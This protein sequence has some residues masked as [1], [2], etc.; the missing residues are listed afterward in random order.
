MVD[1]VIDGKLRFLYSPE[2]SHDVTFKVPSCVLAFAQTEM[3]RLFMNGID[4]DYKTNILR[5]VNHVLE[6]GYPTLV[7]RA[8]EKVIGKTRA[9]KVMRVLKAI[10]ERMTR[11]FLAGM[12]DYES[13][14]HSSP[15][16][17]IVEYLPKEELAALAESLVNLTSLKRHVTRGAETVGGPIDVAVISRGDGFIWI[18]RKH[19]FNKELNPY[20]LATYY[21]EGRDETNKSST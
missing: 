16:V 14:Q 19:Y 12:Q 5:F 21:N 13:K 7:G 10:G 11:S 3:I 17:E 8:L 9:N 20:F 15:I 6:D 18:K 4:S 2:R 1:A